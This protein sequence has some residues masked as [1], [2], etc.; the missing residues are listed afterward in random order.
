[1]QPAARLAPLPGAPSIVEG[2][3]DLRGDAIPVIEW[4]QL[5]GIPPRPI[6]L[7]DRLV[8]VRTAARRVALRVD[9]VADLL[10]AP[11][12][13]VTTAIAS[14]SAGLERAG[15]ARL[16]DGL[17]VIFDPDAFLTAGESETLQAALAAADESAA[18][19]RG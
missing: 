15:L 11:A 19:E 10:T 1:M 18:V 9:G 5:L 12:V 14:T 7:S 13:E 3:L 8:M 6:R 16:S 4:R 17:V 2:L